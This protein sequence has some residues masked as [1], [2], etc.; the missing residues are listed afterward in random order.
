MKRHNA[1]VDEVIRSSSVKVVP[2]RFAV[3]KTLSI[4]SLSDFFMVAKDKD[5]IT[6]ILK[7][8]HLGSIRH[9]DIQQWF[10]LVEIVVSVPFFAVGFLASITSAIA[11]RGLNVLVVSTFSKDYLLIR[12]N[13][14]HEAI[15]SL[16][17]L[18]F[19][20]KSRKLI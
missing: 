1:Q 10:K 18:G 5:E 7:E 20:I 2:G 12:E 19:P 6:V 15:E 16:K 11:S 9:E 14:I 8:D 4:S 3:V 13:V 17:D